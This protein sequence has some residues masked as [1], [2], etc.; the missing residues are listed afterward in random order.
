LN[1]GRAALDIRGEI[2]TYEEF[3]VD[4]TEYCVGYD[5]EPEDALIKEMS[6]T[7]EYKW[8]CSGLAVDDIKELVCLN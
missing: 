5:F 8:Y 1:N 6:W 2:P 3:I 7:T 4:T